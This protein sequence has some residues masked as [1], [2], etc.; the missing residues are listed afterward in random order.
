MQAAIL[1]LLF[2]SS[3]IA[4]KN[5]ACKLPNGGTGP[6]P[7][8][9]QSMEFTGGTPNLAIKVKNTGAEEY[10]G[11]HLRMTTEGYGCILFF[12]SWQAGPT[13]LNTTCDWGFCH[14]NGVFLLPHE[15]KTNSVN[16]TQAIIMAEK[17]TGCCTKNPECGDC[18][19]RG[20]ATFLGVGNR[21][22]GVV[23]MSFFCDL[24]TRRNCKIT[25]PVDAISP[26]VLSPVINIDTPVIENGTPVIENGTPVI[27]NGTP[28]IQNNAEIVVA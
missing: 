3:A 23:E 16:F 9:I 11:G 1:C 12:C 5:L 13:L 18:I 27:E 19:L 4:W 20:I 6:C 21:E 14:P 25:F 8:Q 26:P 2:V 7:I 15:E 22:L 28:V 24:K 17:T 10:V